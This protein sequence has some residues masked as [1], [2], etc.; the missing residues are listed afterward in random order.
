MDSSHKDN[1]SQQRKES[2][3][4]MVHSTHSNLETFDQATRDQQLYYQQR[5]QQQQAEQDSNSSAPSSPT[6]ARSAAELGQ[7]NSAVQLDR[8][9]Q[10]SRR[11][12]DENRQKASGNTRSGSWT[13]SP[14]EL[15]YVE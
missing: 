9:V 5:Q 14:N 10:R 13:G 7:I 1:L 15:P 11:V 2:R 8:D 6:N 4:A 3:P 12:A